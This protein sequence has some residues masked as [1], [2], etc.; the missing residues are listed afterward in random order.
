MNILVNIYHERPAGE[1]RRARLQER[2]A[3][4]SRAILTAADIRVLDR[5]VRRVL[6]SSFPGIEAH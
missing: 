5:E 3:D 4:D 2:L 6:V 1:S